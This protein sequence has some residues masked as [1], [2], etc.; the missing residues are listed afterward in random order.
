[1]LV[2]AAAAA[3]SAKAEELDGEL[4][5]AATELQA[6]GDRYVGHFRPIINSGD[7]EASKAAWAHCEAVVW[8]REDE[9]ID[10]II[11]TPARTPEGI[12]SKGA[13]LELW[14]NREVPTFLAD[15]FEDCADQHELLA[16]SFARDVL[17]RDVS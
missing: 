14:L 2:L 9:L 17:G 6:L 1:M 5:S 16:M 12:R 8:P 7:E 11:A 3:G 15:T 13:I 4:I 10:F